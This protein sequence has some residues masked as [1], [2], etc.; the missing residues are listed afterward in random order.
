MRGGQGTICGSRFSPPTICILE[1]KL[2]SFGLATSTRAYLKKK[3]RLKK[4]F[5]MFERL[6]ECMLCVPHPCPM[7]MEAGKGALGS[8]GTGVTVASRRMDDGNG[9]GVLCKSSKSSTC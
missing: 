3:I 2:R 4:I 6:S 7:P 8:A 5:Y 1:I 9:T